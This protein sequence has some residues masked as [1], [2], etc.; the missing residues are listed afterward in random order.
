MKKQQSIKEDIICTDRKKYKLQWEKHKAN[1]DD[2]FSGVRYDP[3]EATVFF[4]FR[5]EDGKVITVSL[6]EETK[7]SG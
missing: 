5:Q 2:V 7:I 1:F 3:A 4:S 6:K